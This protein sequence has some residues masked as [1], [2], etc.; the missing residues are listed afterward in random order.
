MYIK[1]SQV[2]KIKKSVLKNTIQNKDI[3]AKLTHRHTKKLNKL[4]IKILEKKSHF[5]QLNKFLLRI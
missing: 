4:M 2:L 3:D 5:H 1:L